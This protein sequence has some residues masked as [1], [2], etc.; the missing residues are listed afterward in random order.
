MLVA[1]CMYSKLMATAGGENCAQKQR[2][3]ARNCGPLKKWKE[4]QLMDGKHLTSFLFGY[5]PHQD[6]ADISEVRYASF[7][8]VVQVFL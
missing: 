5:I 3:V 7:C 6:C 2:Q 4:K 8:Q 1:T